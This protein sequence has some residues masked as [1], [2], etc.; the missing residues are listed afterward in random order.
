MIN[1]K[2][3]PPSEEHSDRSLEMSRG[4][5]ED[6]NYCR[7]F[8]KEDRRSQE[9]YSTGR[10]RGRAWAVCFWQGA[11]W[12]RREA[13]F[14]RPRNVGLKSLDTTLFASVLHCIAEGWARDTGAMTSRAPSWG[15]PQGPEPD[16]MFSPCWNACSFLS[17]FA[18]GWSP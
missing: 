9:R 10:Q 16:A 11:T 12:E 8:P 17:V 14:G 3:G 13:R 6:R 2:M 5:A 4:A 18:S 1:T 15:I 7:R